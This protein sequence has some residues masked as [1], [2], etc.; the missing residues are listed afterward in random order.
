MIKDCNDPVPL[1]PSFTQDLYQVHVGES[2]TFTYDGPTQPKGVTLSWVTGIEGGQNLQN[3]NGAT[4]SFRYNTAGS[5]FVKLEAINCNFDQPE[6]KK[7][8]CVTVIP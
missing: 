4:I 8:P 6:I 2:V 1:Q 5:Y 7:T 3:G